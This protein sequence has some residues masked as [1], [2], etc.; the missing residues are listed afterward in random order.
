[1]FI[2]GVCLTAGIGIGLF[3]VPG[4]TAEYWAWTIKAPLTAAFFGAGYIGAAVALSWGAAT[5]EWQRVRT[6]VVIALTLTSLALLDTLRHLGGFSFHAGGLVE[7]VAWFWLAVYIALPPL[8][9]VAFVLQERGGGAH[10]YGVDRP[11]LPGSRLAAAVAGAMSAIVGVLLLG[12]LSWLRTRWP[13][14]LP[15][16]P[17]T[18]MGAWLCTVGSGLLWFA[19]R[20]RTWYRARIG[21]I[22]MLVPLGLDLVAAAV[23]T[24][25]IGAVAIVE[26]RRPTPR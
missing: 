25:V 20:E 17:A 10:E 23:L 6:V 22:A 19:L 21:V 7:V 8:L 1:V 5:R 4:R 11:A 18:I 16:L 14:P 24:A 9:A 13:W 15:S 3:A 12:E 26:E 2:L